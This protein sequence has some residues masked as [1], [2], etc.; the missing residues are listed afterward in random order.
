MSAPKI[1]GH[2]CPKIDKLKGAIDRSYKI[3]D[4]CDS[5]D[6]ETLKAALKDIRYELHGESD[7]LEVLRDANLAL[8]TAAEYW[9]E[10]FSELEATS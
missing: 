9:E 3:A 4:Q 6:V 8:R 5:D 10:K 1:P 2:T 7:A